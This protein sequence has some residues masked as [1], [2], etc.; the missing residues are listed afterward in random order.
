MVR[1]SRARRMLISRARLRR[2]GSAQLAGT[3]VLVAIE[4]VPFASAPDG[5]GRAAL[6]CRDDCGCDCLAAA[7]CWPGVPVGRDELDRKDPLLGRRRRRVEELAV[8]DW[9]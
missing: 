9:L 2:I 7:D 8:G 1:S 3:R 5:V 4:V 6:A